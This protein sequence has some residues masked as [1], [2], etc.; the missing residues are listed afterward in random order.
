M[1]K[2]I[3]A[4]KGYAIGHVYLKKK[5]EIMID[6]SEVEDIDNHLSILKDAIEES[7]KQIIQIRDKAILEIGEEEALVFDSHLMFLEDPE[8]IETAEMAIKNERKSA[9]AAVSDVTKTFCNLFSQMDN[10]YMKERAADI[11]DVGFRVLANILGIREDEMKK[12]GENTIVVSHDLTPSDTAQL[13]KT[14]VI[15]FL[16]DVGGVTSHSAIMARSLQIPAVVGLKNVTQK[17]E[18]G[19]LIIIDGIK[20]EVI[21][22]PDELTLLQY[23]EMEKAYQDEKEGL[24]AYKDTELYYSSERKILVAANIG[25]AQE[26]ELV[27]EN[28]ADGIGLFRT[29]FMFMDRTNMPSEEEQFELY[30]TVAEKLK[31]RPVVIRTLDIGGDKQIPYLKTEH[32]ENPFLGLRAIRLCLKEQDLFKSQ[33]KALLRAAFYGE[34]QIMFPMIGSLSQLLETKSLLEVCKE[35]LRSANIPFKSDIAIGMMIEIPSAALIAEE[36]AKHV[37]F[38]S[39]GTNDLIQYTLAIDRMNTNVAHLYDPMH[40]AVL[41]LI[42]MT[43]EAAHKNGIWCG[44]CGEMAGDERAIPQ[45]VKMQLDEFSVSP[46]SVLA[47]RKSI[48]Q[49]LN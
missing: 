6:H 10:A 30:K 25:S 39:I 49:I 27:L 19:M 11:K 43:I 2:G 20:G 36:F 3:A 16:T 21:L 31:D 45:L 23:K 15:G 4:S 42:Q 37:Q 8:F 13:D 7:K 26:L 40:P 44:M 18:N 35:E 28:K 29:E 17:V 24:K 41:S 9:T 1:I 22:N 32:E 48:A 46:S 47:V 33:L 12:I 14:K 34:I 5:Q 38:F